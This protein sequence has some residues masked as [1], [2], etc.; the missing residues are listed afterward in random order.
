MP[1]VHRFGDQNIAGGAVNT[2]PQTSVFANEKL[3]SVVGSRGTAD[4]SCSH[5]NIHCSGNW[6][7]TGGTSTVFVEGIPI[8]LPGDIDTCGHPRSA[9]ASPDVFAE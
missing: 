8:N 6:A 4:S 9:V 3:I 7:T 5:N 2:I 1:A